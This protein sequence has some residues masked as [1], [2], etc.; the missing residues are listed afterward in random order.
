MKVTKDADSF[1]ARI[2]SLDKRRTLKT[3]ETASVLE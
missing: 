3:R 1:A 2:Y